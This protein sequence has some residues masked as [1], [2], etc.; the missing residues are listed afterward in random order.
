[1]TTMFNH[2]NIVSNGWIGFMK[3]SKIR[4]TIVEKLPACMTTTFAKGTSKFDMEK[5]V[6]QG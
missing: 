1:M 6:K 3:M 5:I 2:Q 4:M